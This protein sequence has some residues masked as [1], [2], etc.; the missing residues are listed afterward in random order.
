MAKRKGGPQKAAIRNY[1]ENNYIRIKDATDVNS[2]MRDMMSVLLE[3]AWAEKLDEEL[4][5][6]YK[7][8]HTNYRDID[9]TIPR[10]VTVIMNR[11]RLKS[12]RIP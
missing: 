4:G 3:D 9:I 5:Y 8:M 6:S 1:L 10:N 7:T 12:I 11:I 2:N